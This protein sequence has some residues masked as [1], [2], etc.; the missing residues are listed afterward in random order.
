MKKF[1]QD[2]SGATSIEYVLIASG[3]AVGIIVTIFAFGSEVSSLYDQI[4]GIDF[5]N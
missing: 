5:T 1:I 2:Q 4:G 3:I